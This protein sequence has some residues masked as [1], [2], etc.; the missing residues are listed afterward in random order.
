M[1]IPP[2]AN[3]TIVD[4]KLLWIGYTLISKSIMMEIH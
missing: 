1:Q 4:A 2:N 3:I